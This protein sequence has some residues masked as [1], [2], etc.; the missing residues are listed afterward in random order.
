MS[1]ITSRLDKLLQSR[2]MNDMLLYAH[3]ISNEIH[4]PNLTGTIN[5]EYT[6]NEAVEELGLDYDLIDQ[7]LEDYVSQ[8]IKA[9]ITFN[10][11][12]SEL[13]D[14]KIYTTNLDYTFLRELAH[15]NLGVARNLR[16]E[17]S[18]RLLDKIMRDDNLDCLALCV[19]YL[20]AR[21]IILKPEHAYKT[22]HLIKLKES[23]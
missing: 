5:I 15:K 20:L 19:E 6:A 11:Y 14:L 7:L 9:C 10:E 3:K 8:G 22:I 13:K 4:I 1:N 18:E 23:F 16:I 12:I 2:S 17:D 21:I